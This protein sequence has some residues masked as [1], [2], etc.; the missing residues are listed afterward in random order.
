MI[1]PGI[2]LSAV[3]E[4]DPGIA[5]DLPLLFCNIPGPDHLLR[6]GLTGANALTSHLAPV[7]PTGPQHFAGR[8]MLRAYQTAIV[9]P[10]GEGILAVQVFL[11]GVYHGLRR[12]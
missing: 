11:S 1:R 7:A 6:K 3:V 5:T 12:L 10:A 9:D 8:P 2:S 4:R